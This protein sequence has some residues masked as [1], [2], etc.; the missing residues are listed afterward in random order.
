MLI[1]VISYQVYHLSDTRLAPDRSNKSTQHLNKTDELR[2]LRGLTSI[3]ALT[4]S[5]TITH[6][7]FK[8]VIEFSF[9]RPIYH[10]QFG[11][12]SF[13]Q[14]H[15]KKCIR[16]LESFHQD[17]MNFS[18]LRRCIFKIYINKLCFIKKFAT[19]MNKETSSSLLGVNVN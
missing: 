1:S 8:F 4:Q 3:F 11:K 18:S 14:F 10:P 2:L 17:N 6:Q 9:T 16:E 5:T 12:D 13:V 7:Y 19:L 15:L